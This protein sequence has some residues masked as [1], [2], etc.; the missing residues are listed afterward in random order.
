[1]FVGQEILKWSFKQVSCLS[2][3]QA[4]HD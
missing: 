4:P 2:A 3:F 1:M